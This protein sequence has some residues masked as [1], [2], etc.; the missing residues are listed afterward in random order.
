MKGTERNY[1]K[2]NIFCLQYII[3]TNMTHQSP[4][5]FNYSKTADISAVSLKNSLA[6]T[7]DYNIDIC[8][9]ACAIFRKLFRQ[10]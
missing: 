8:A 9:Y 2:E 5:L 10:I 6:Q 4:F 7:D 3:L 1:Y